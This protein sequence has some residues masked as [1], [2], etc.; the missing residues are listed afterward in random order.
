M[1]SYAKIYCQA[2]VVVTLIHPYTVPPPPIDTPYSVTTT[3]TV[4]SLVSTS[5]LLVITFSIWRGF[6][7][8]QELAI[9]GWLQKACLINVLICF[10]WF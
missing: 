9:V 1:S 4:P 8:L 6:F 2:C 10:T 3:P 5:I 7:S